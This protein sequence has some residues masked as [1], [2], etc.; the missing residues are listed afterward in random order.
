[1]KK[2]KKNIFLIGTRW[3]GVL[4]QSKFLIEYLVKENF[5][6]YIFGQ[7]DIYYKQ[8]NIKNIHLNEI[9]IKPSYFSFISDL[10]DFFKVL[11]FIIKLK[12]VA[13]HTF[14]P[15]PMI[16]GFFLVI[17]FKNIKFFVAQTG[18]G[19]LFQKKRVLI[20]LI[21]LLIKLAHNRSSSVFFHNNHDAQFL[22]KKRLIQKKKIVFIG[23]CVD[24]KK[25]I[26]IDKKFN[27]RLTRIICISRLLKQKGVIEF[28]EVARKFKSE[29]NLPEVEFLL[30]GEIEKHHYDKIDEH[31]IIECENNSIIKRISWS[32]D[33]KSLLRKSDI[34]FL[35][36]YREGGPRVIIEAAACQIP[37]IGSNAVGVRDLIIHNKTGF[38]TE[39]KNINSAYRAVKKLVTNRILLKKFGRNALNLIAKPISLESATN[40]QIISYKKS[41]VLKN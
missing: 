3:F 32:N 31:F 22:Q 30:V 4:G 34:L 29:K 2:N 9:N 36:S 38:I 1:M 16:L 25:F 17:F 12:P 18:M 35:H 8:F 15:K 41:K 33:I 28:I 39:V 21:S 37:T 40:K 6:V 14:N 19:N 26:I 24:V 7:K 27:K 13:I 11:Y 20:P 23:P 10:I 5:D